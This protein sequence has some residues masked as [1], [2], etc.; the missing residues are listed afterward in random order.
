MKNECPCTMR[1]SRI[2]FEPTTYTVGGD[3][4]LVYMPCL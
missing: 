3:F 1:D 4:I 2:F